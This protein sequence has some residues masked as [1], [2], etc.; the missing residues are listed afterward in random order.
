MPSINALLLDGAALDHFLRAAAMARALALTTTAQWVE[1]QGN[2]P[3]EV[4]YA[5][6]PWKAKPGFVEVQTAPASELRSR[7]QRLYLQFCRDFAENSR[8]GP[9]SLVKW[10]T[11]VEHN[12]EEDRRYVKR[13][14]LEALTINRQVDA[15]LQKEINFLA[16]VKLMSEVALL[17]LGTTGWGFG[18]AIVTRLGVG[19]SYPV[20]V[21]VLTDFRQAHNADMIATTTQSNLA[22]SAPSLSGDTLTNLPKL[23]QTAPWYTLHFWLTDKRFSEAK[24]LTREASRKFRLATRP[25]AN[26]TARQVAR[27]AA[28]TRASQDLARQAS[29]VEFKAA[30]G[31]MGIKVLAVPLMTVSIW[32]TLKGTEQAA[33]DYWNVIEQNSEMGF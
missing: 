24:Q 6:F 28:R 25:I 19:V 3:F 17:V 23:G 11:Q 21:N 2:A 5:A 13:L 7:S 33:N 1:Y 14:D 29:R 15:Q 22:Q 16:T 27:A 18:W 31:K 32:F 8:R 10:M 26:P 20:L 12:F 30:L 4:I 9:P